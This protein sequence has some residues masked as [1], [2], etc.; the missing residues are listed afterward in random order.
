M[1]HE[2]LLLLGEMLIGFIP[3]LSIGYVIGRGYL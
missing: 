2:H 1:S 3:G